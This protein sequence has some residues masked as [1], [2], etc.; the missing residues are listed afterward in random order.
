MRTTQE[1]IEEMIRFSDQWC[2]ACMKEFDKVCTLNRKENG[3]WLIS[4]KPRR[5]NCKYLQPTKS[6]TIENNPTLE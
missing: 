2:G 3:I 5:K 6:N 4:P 1:M